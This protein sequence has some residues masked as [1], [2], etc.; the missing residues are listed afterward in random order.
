[1]SGEGYLA[2]AYVVVL[3]AVLVYLAIHSLRLVRLER[4]VAELARQAAAR[5]RDAERE[6][7]SVGR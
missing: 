4:E 1:M 6:E 3:V 5:E 2:A 7:V